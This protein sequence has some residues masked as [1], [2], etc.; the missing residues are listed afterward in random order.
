MFRILAVKPGY[1][2]AMN[3]M[4]HLCFPTAYRLDRVR[5]CCLEFLDMVPRHS[6]VPQ[7]QRPVPASP[8]SMPGCLSPTT[9]LLLPRAAP[10][11]L[12]GGEPLD[13]CR[14]PGLLN[15]GALELEGGC[16]L[17]LGSTS[18]QALALALALGGSSLRSRGKLSPNCYTLR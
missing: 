16:S 12:I 13:L 2:G 17:F 6:T 3:P 14:R 11:G 18:L 5:V 1:M 10:K 7:S 15:H 8:L 4:D 9:V